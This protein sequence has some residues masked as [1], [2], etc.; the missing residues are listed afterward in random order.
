MSPLLSTVTVESLISIFE[1][2]T[3]HALTVASVSLES[4]TFLRVLLPLASEAKK[5]AR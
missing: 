3:L 2:K 1:P 4:K 5:I